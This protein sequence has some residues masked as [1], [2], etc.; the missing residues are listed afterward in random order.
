MPQRAVHLRERMDD[1][2]CDPD[3][4]LRTYRQFIWVNRLFSGWRRIFANYFAPL[5]PDRS[6][7]YTL[8][9]IGFGGGDIP[10]LLHRIAVRHGHRLKITAL[11]ADDRAFGYVEQRTWPETISFARAST[12]ELRRADASFDFVISNHLMHHLDDDSLRALLDDADALADQMVLF[13]D[14]RRH[15]LAY[16]G[17][18][19]SMRPF[20]WNSYLVEDGLTSIR[21]SYTADELRAVVPPEWR[22][23]TFFPFR[24]FLI[25]KN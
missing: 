7:E 4:L 22:V 13:N 1:P 20:F 5:M 14:I 10:L 11:D 8:L 18:A 25:R 21:R 24:L 23:Q 9:D 2:D 3:K 12:S 19:L 15:P 6:R 17:F 16:A